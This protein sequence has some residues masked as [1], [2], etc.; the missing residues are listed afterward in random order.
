VAGDKPENIYNISSISTYKP[1]KEWR[2][3]ERP[4]ERLLSNGPSSLSDSELLAIVISTGTKSVSALD[5]ARS[6]LERFQSLSE[7]ASR[8]VSELKSIKG[9]G[10]AKA[11][12]LSAVFEISRRIQ[13]FNLDESTIFHSPDDVANYFIP[14]LFGLKQE[15]FYVVLLNSSNRIIRVKL[16]T[17]GTLTASL[18]HPREVFRYAITEA[19]ASIILVHNHPS[20]NP[21]PSADDIEMTKKLVSAGKLID[22]P[23]LDHLIIAGKNFTSFARL[24]LLT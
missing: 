18:V 3:D 9:I 1:I 7:L 17:E 24:G 11:V 22:I 16:V 19:A 14:R 13:S 15:R 5:L 21:Q 12:T 23:V 20:G 4:R 8:D 2:K 6:L 10:T